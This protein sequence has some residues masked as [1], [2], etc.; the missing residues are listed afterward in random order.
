M[1]AYRMLRNNMVMR[2]RLAGVSWATI[3]KMLLLYGQKVV[4]HYVVLKEKGGIQIYYGEPKNK[5]ATK[6]N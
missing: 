1:I 3:N 6:I 2:M 5:K 4:T